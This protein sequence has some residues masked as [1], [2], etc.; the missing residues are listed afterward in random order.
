[1][2]DGK[3]GDKPL[4]RASFQLVMRR[5]GNQAVLYSPLLRY[6]ILIG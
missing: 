4:N 1:M 6:N 5:G 2:N 3:R